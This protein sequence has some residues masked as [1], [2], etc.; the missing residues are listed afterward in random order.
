MSRVTSTRR[1]TLQC[2]KKGAIRNSGAPIVGLSRLNRNPHAPVVDSPFAAPTPRSSVVRRTKKRPRC[3]APEAQGRKT[4]TG[5]NHTPSRDQHTEPPLEAWRNA[6][7]EWIKSEL[8][9]DARDYIRALYIAE[10]D[11]GVSYEGLRD[12]YRRCLKDALDFA[13]DSAW[14]E[15]KT[16]A[17]AVAAEAI[18]AAFSEAA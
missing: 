14:A 2:A 7:A 15:T 4:L 13:V 17:D 18:R 1:P 12:E 6:A 8:G 10:K 3:A 11:W 5:H 16:K 9:R